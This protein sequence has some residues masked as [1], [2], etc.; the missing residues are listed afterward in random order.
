[1]TSTSAHVRSSARAANRPP[2]PQPT[3]TIRAR[4][5]NVR[6]LK[7]TQT[8]ECDV[9]A[10][11]GRYKRR[12]QGRVLA[13]GGHGLQTQPSQSVDQAAQGEQH[14]KAAD[15]GPARRPCGARSEEHTSELQSPCNLVCRLLLE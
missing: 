3:I 14:R 6:L 2:K 4:P 12:K 7:G 9:G 11:I 5:V 10:I 15:L 8:Q 1:M 13:G